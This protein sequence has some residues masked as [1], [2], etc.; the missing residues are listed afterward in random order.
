MKF[1]KEELS[2]IIKICDAMSKIKDAREYDIICEPKVKRMT[3][4]ILANSR[5]DAVARFQKQNPDLRV[6]FVK[7]S[8]E[9]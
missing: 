8:F 6:I 1:T 9:E 7:E 3:K 2:G 4:V 5:Q